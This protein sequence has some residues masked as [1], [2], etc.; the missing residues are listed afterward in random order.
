MGFPFLSSFGSWMDLR[1][2]DIIQIIQRILVYPTKWKKE[3]PLLSGRTVNLW[4]FVQTNRR[5]ELKRDWIP[6]W[7][8][9]KNDI[10]CILPSRE[11]LKNRIASVS[12]S[13]PD[14]TA[15]HLY[16]TKRKLNSSEKDKKDVK[17]IS[18]LG[19]GKGTNIFQG[20]GKRILLNGILDYS[21]SA[22]LD[23]AYNLGRIVSE[24]IGFRKDLSETRI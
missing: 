8:V 7:S 3:N 2:K 15:F 13:F 17:D 21:T 4:T 9:D 5:V 1:L 19:E 10:V 18:L 22:V 20:T 11:V 23:L 6:V 12:G 24:K 14:V 16:R